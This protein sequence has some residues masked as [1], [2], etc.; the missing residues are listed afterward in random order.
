MCR[1]ADEGRCTSENFSKTLNKLALKTKTS[2]PVIS[3]HA[4][5]AN[6][7]SGSR[8]RFEVI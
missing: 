2:D 1:G 7:K 4:V 5:V 3:I 6:D 8:A